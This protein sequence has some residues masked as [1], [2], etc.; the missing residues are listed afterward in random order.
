MDDNREAL[1]L[2]KS[3]IALVFGKAPPASASHAPPSSTAAPAG[4][5]ALTAVDQL[6]SARLAALVTTRHA[7]ACSACF[8]CCAWALCPRAGWPRA[9]HACLHAARTGMGHASTQNP[10]CLRAC[11]PCCYCAQRACG[12]TAREM[13]YWRRPLP[14]QARAPQY[15]LAVQAV[16][17]AGAQLV[18][19]RQQLVVLLLQAALGSRAGRE[20]RAAAV[21]MATGGLQV[22]GGVQG[23]RE[24]SKGAA[25]EVGW[26]GVAG[27]VE[28]LAQGL[29]Q[30]MG[31]MERQGGQEQ[32]GP[33]AVVPHPR[34]QQEGG[35]Q[36]GRRCWAC[37]SREAGSSQAQVR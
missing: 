32:V 20:A 28:L 30:G 26:V 1:D 14:T 15:S 21:A 25:R 16:Q 3:Y 10:A 5:G 24:G 31:E 19:T 12:R 37:S 17:E 4:L 6:Q 8:A 11:P 9:A 35:R 2:A 29:P 18:A 36:Q 33:A 23:G 34:E 7:P 22:Q 27:Q 13:T